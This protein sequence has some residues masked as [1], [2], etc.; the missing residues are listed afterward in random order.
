MFFSK[1]TAIINIYENTLIVYRVVIKGDKPVIKEKIVEKIDNNLGQLFEIVKK[2][3]SVSTARILLDDT[4][5]HLILF[6]LPLTETITKELVFQKATQL[7]PEKI[8]KDFT[9]W[10]QVGLTKDRKNAK[11]QF[12]AVSKDYLLPII[13]AAQNSNLN[14]EA[15]EPASFSLARLT[16]KEKLP[17]LIIYQQQ[18]TT[19]LTT[20]FSGFVLEVAISSKPDLNSKKK[21]TDFTSEKW[22]VTIEKEI[23]AVDQDP[24]IGLALKKDLKGKDEKVLNLPMP[25]LKSIT[26]EEKM[27]SINQSSQLNHQPDE[28]FQSG[29]S[30]VNPLSEPTIIDNPPSINESSKNK[31]YIIIGVVL[32]LIIVAAFFFLK[33]DKPDEK[34]DQTQKEQITPTKTPSPTPEPEIAKDELTLLVQNGSGVE[35]AAGS[36]ASTLEDLGYQQPDTENADNYDY[37]GLTIKVKE[38]K[39]DIYDLLYQDL[40]N[41]FDQIEQ[42]TLDEDSEYDA[43]LIIGAGKDDQQELEVDISQEEEVLGDSTEQ[44]VQE[45]TPTEEVQQ[46]STNSAET[47]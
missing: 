16:Q 29:Q 15:F 1:N 46:D 12:L 8:E 45:P 20:C 35:G 36:L 27:E 44:E 23:K 41:E 17:H 5:T 22:N 7:I 14:I 38:D 47:E 43:V 39:D 2:T 6:D 33:K 30:S 9:D 28:N 11:I 40:E 42:E 25:K 37:V 4:K 19:L 26:K 3:F 24:V 34:K 13:K 18:K 32:V 21:L 10:K 31:K